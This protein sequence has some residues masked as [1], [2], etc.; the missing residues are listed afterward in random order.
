MLETFV[1]DSFKYDPTLI[2]RGELEDAPAWRE[3]YLPALRSVVLHLPW[4]YWGLFMEEELRAIE[5]RAVGFELSVRAW[6]GE[7]APLVSGQWW[8]QEVS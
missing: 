8:G 2:A 1:V 7:L 3:R 6:E 5:A 4:R